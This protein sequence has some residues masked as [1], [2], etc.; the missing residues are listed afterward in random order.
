MT[1]VY[2]AFVPE[3]IY[4][5]T[6]VTV[7][8]SWSGSGLTKDYKVFV[9]FVEIATGVTRFQNDHSPPTPTSQWNG[10]VQY[11]KTV[12]APELKPNGKYKV[13]AGL[14]ESGIGRIPLNCGPGVTHDGSY[15]YKVAEFYLSGKEVNDFQPVYEIVPGDNVQAALSTVAPGG[16]LIF[17]P[18]TYEHSNIL[19]LQQANHV[20]LKGYG[21]ELFA[22]TVKKQ[23]LWIKDSN[24]VLI[25]GFIHNSVAEAREQSD[26]SCAVL[27]SNSSEVSIID[28]HVK[29]TA[30]AGIHFNKNSSEFYVLNCVIENTLADGVH[31][32]DNCHEGTVAGNIFR[33]TGDDC[34]GIIGYSK[35]GARI[36]NMV[37]EDNTIENNFHGRG[38]AIEGGESV[39]VAYNN[40]SSTSSAGIIIGS[41]KNYSTYGSSDVTVYGNKLYN[42]NFNLSVAHGG[43]FVNGYDGD[44]D[45]IFLSNH[46]VKIV[47][48]QVEETINGSAHIRVNQYNSGVEIVDN[49]IIDLDDSKKAI[50]VATQLDPSQYVMS[51]NTYN[52]VDV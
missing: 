7:M 15:R 47:D 34:V 48:N 12:K 9:H 50:A 52:G 36:K 33:H 30:G 40:I 4:S 22:T 39:T 35:H 21:A 45:G 11:F 2:G 17:K 42:C 26:L 29:G 3:F 14:Y 46:N 1:T 18:G 6:D 27:V 28:S 10:P 19:V 32:T 5:G 31:I 37:I 13:L 51:G 23:A 38:I 20:C 8:Y 25:R 24:D 44:L 16:T 49:I 43:I 41:N